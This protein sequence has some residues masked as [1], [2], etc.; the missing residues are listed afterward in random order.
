ERFLTM[1]RELKNNTAQ[2]LDHRHP[3]C[4]YP[5]LSLESQRENDN[6]RDMN[7]IS[8][9][10]DARNQLYEWARDHG[11]ESAMTPEEEVE[12]QRLQ[13]DARKEIG[14]LGYD[15]LANRIFGA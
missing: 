5:M 15:A 3:M 1:L 13:V 7:I 8:G 12:E 9:A 2:G 14:T 10:D 4:L 11:S 6:H